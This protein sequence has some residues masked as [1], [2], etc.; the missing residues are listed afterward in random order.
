MDQLQNA[1]VLIKRRGAPF[2][3]SW[4]KTLTD[5]GIIDIAR[6]SSENIKRLTWAMKV[7]SMFPELEAKS[8]RAIVKK[9]GELDIY[10]AQLFL[11]KRGVPIDATLEAL[12]LETPYK[13]A[14]AIKWSKSAIPEEVQFF[15]QL[16]DRLRPSFAEAKRLAA[17]TEDK[18]ARIRFLKKF[19]AGSP[20]EV[21][22]AIQLAVRDDFKK[23]YKA[24]VAYFKR[25][26]ALLRQDSNYINESGETHSSGE[27]LF[28]VFFEMALAGYVADFKPQDIIDYIHNTS[29]IK[30]RGFFSVGDA[31][32][33]LCKG[34]TPEKFAET[35]TNCRALLKGEELPNRLLADITSLG[36]DVERVI[37]DGVGRVDTLLKSLRLLPSSVKVKEKIILHLQIL[38]SG[39]TYPEVEDMILSGRSFGVRLSPRDVMN[40]TYFGITIEEWVKMLEAR[41]EAPDQFPSS[42]ILFM[43]RL[44]HLKLGSIDF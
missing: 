35:M 11:E 4:E 17:L 41:K 19:I 43:T 29:E 38:G 31:I 14:R 8:P 1:L 26:V 3:A 7:L 37:G 13:V 20:A 2:A 5:E 32:Y 36:E 30:F 27:E 34:I 23:E 25:F 18:E 42:D 9:F 12:R 40:L 28:P 33:C 22:C 16:P 39:Y 6:Y 24:A 44:F 10:L 21:R 15:N